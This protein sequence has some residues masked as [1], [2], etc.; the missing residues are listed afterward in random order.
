MLWNY[1]Y[2]PSQDEFNALAKF[3]VVSKTLLEQPSA[4]VASVSSPS[5]KKVEAIGLYRE[6]RD[7]MKA[8]FQLLDTNHDQKLSVSESAKVLGPKMSQ[9]ML[10]AMLEHN[11]NARSDGELTLMDWRSFF[12][13]AAERAGDTMSEL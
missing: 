5:K 4:E 7:E 11:P 9:H 6:I 10:S 13:T 2:K 1:R 12:H 8:V 3:L